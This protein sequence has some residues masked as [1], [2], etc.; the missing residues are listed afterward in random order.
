M[1]TRAH[2]SLPEAAC[3]RYDNM[4]FA[5]CLLRFCATVVA[6]TALIVFFAFSGSVTHVEPT[7]RSGAAPATERVADAATL[8]APVPAPSDA[9]GSPTR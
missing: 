2:A 4:D 7:R 3:E 9:G 1:P 5:E 6:W 8:V